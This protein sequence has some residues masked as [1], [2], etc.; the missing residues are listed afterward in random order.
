MQA[1]IDYL[2]YLEQC[3]AELHAAN[4]SLP[5]PFP[6]QN[7]KSVPRSHS[8]NL[9][10]L[11]EDED[12]ESED[13]DEDMPMEEIQTKQALPSSATSNSSPTAST[14]QNSSYQQYALPHTST[15]TTTLP[16]PLF[17]HQSSE[18]TNPYTHKTQLYLETSESKT[19]SP[20]LL[21]EGMRDADHEATAALLMLNADR[22]DAMDT[23]NSG[24]GMSVQD[25]LSA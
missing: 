3:V 20:T 25:L 8:P 4:N 22:R 15:T 9:S 13:D 5:S 1:S 17:M 11:D 19:T 24:R 12:E 21:S 10:V 6:N 7:Q 14:A 18:N 16:S 23:R 2:R